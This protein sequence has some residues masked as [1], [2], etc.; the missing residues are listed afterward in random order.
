MLLAGVPHKLMGGISRINTY[1]IEVIIQYCLSN[2][3]VQP[4]NYCVSQNFLV[5]YVKVIG[6]LKL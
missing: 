3:L 4:F 2:Q 5:P 6:S 1:L